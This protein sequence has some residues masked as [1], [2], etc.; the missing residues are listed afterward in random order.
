MRMQAQMDERRARAKHVPHAQRATSVGLAHWLQQG[1]SRE[2]A[3]R[4]AHDRSGIS[5]T[6]L[7]REPGVSVGWISK[8]IQRAER[9]ERGEKQ[10]AN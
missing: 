8:L 3:L 7:A 9:Q 2:Q 10:C 4:A 1:L 6:Q 5:M